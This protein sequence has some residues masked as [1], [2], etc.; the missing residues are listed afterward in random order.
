MEIPLALRERSDGALVYSLPAAF[1]AAM[2]AV[3]AILALAL[4]IEGGSPGVGGWIALALA[5]FGGLY[6]EKWTF[7]PRRGEAAHRAGLVFL[8]RSTMIAMG[9][10]ERFRLAPYVRGTLPGSAD[11]AA[12]NEAALSGERADDSGKRR[13]RHKKPYLCLVCETRDGA[14]YLVNIASARKG[15]GLKAQAARIAAA[16]E[17][18][19]IE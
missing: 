3:A 12:E 6:E 17:A 1:R 2:A 4:S 19:L 8:A 13:A 15:A 18:P 5:V 7:D 14:R 9:D 16:C 11:E 10:I